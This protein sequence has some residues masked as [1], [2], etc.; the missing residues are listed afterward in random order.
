MIDPKDDD[1][2]QRALAKIAQALDVP[3]ETFLDPSAFGQDHPSEADQESELIELFRR[4]KDIQ[5]RRRCLGFIRSL[6]EQSAKP[7]V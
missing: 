3:I 6:T 7:K 1:Q 5:A 4:V 2:E